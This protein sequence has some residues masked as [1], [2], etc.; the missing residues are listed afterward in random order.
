MSAFFCC[1]IR[2]SEIS[3]NKFLI[4]L[5][6]VQIILRALFHHAVVRHNNLYQVN[7]ITGIGIMENQYGIIFAI[8]YTFPMVVRWLFEPMGNDQEG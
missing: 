3:D 7:M 2:R 6:F 4:E 5:S 1:L 8:N